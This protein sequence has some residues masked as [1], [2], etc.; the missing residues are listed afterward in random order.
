MILFSS[1]LIYLL[2]SDVQQKRKPLAGEIRD[3]CFQ[4]NEVENTNNFSMHIRDR[5]KVKMLEVTRASR[6]NGFEQ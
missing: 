6:H 4:L 2:L 5:L 3:F 1:C